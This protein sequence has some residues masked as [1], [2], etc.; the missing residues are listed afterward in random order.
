MSPLKQIRVRIRTSTSSHHN[1]T[2]RLY[3]YHAQNEF[4]LHLLHHRREDT[5]AHL[6]PIHFDSPLPL[7][8]GSP[9]RAQPAQHL[10]GYSIHM[11]WRRPG[12]SSC[13][14]HFFMYY[15]HYILEPGSLRLAGVYLVYLTTGVWQNS[16]HASYRQQRIPYCSLRISILHLH[17]PVRAQPF[18][19]SLSLREKYYK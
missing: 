3:E 14:Y 17:T 10:H 16:L 6:L 11:G 13:I 9:M 19:R 15:I 8:H 5:H 7:S 2:L 1:H 12:F 18:Q 4:L